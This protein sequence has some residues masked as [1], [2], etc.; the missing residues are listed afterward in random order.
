[1]ETINWEWGALSQ[2]GQLEL[3]KYY[4]FFYIPT[5]ISIKQQVKTIGGDEAD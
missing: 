5:Y 4:I 3:Y 1:L 2:L